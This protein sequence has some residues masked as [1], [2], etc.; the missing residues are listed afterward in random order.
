MFFFGFILLYSAFTR[1]YIEFPCFYRLHNFW[2]AKTNALLNKA[3]ADKIKIG[4]VC[5]RFT[6]WVNLKISDEYPNKSMNGLPPSLLLSSDHPHIRWKTT[7]E[8]LIHTWAL[9]FFLYMN[10]PGS[11]YSMWNLYVFDL[12]D[13][14]LGLMVSVFDG[15]TI[16]PELLMLSCLQ[17]F[18]NFNC[19]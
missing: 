15:H 11:C 16:M 9:D 10:S 19:L 4:E 12:Q 1:C 14:R 18:C 6:Y 2:L 5:A 8:L 3:G 7:P 13:L 17:E